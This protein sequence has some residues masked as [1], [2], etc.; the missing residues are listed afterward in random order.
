MGDRLT[1]E[2]YCRI[3]DLTQL[4]ISFE[5]RDSELDKEWSILYKKS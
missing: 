5:P 4:V 2:D 1:V 3:L